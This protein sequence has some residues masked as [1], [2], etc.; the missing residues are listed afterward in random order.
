MANTIQIKRSAFNGTSAPT[1]LTAGEFAF[2]QGGTPRRVYIGRQ[3]D[4][5]G[6]VEVFHLPT[7]EDLTAGD[8]LAVTAAASS[9][10]R[11]R[12]LSVNVDDDTIEINSDTLR[13]KAD[14]IDDT[15]IDWGTGSGQVSTADVPEQTNLYYTDERVDDRI[16][17]LFV[18]GEGID[19]TYDDGNNT[20]TIAGEDASVTNKGIASFLAADF[21]VASGA[22]SLEDTVVKTITTDSGAL[23]PSTHSLSVLGGEGMNVT[24]SSTTVTVAGEDASDSN[25]GVAK[26]LAADFDNSSGEISL[27]DS[28]LKAITTDT[29]AITMASH[30][31]SVLGGEGM[32][33]THSGTAIT[34]A[35]EDATT[36]N[37]GV[38]SFA[39]A[40]FD[41]SSGAV[42]INSLS[43]SQ[44]DNSTITVG[45]STIA[46]GGSDTTL[47]GLTDID[48]V[49]GDVTIL[50]T[51][52]A[53][54]LTIGASGGT[55][56]IAGNLT[57]SGAASTI[58]STT[59]VVEDPLLKLSK[60]STT[61]TADIGFYGRYSDDAGTTIKYKGI[62]S[63]V[64]NTDT[65]TF[66][67]QTEAEPTTTVNTGG[68]NYALAGIKC[69]SV[70][71]AII[72][73]GA[74]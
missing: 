24:H 5:G 29:G 52:G 53:N 68:T 46:L 12:T 2:L 17:G 58:E 1:V 13:L 67:R 65:W 72:D 14:G 44:L 64:D 28:V 10:V 43:N 36:S 11:E 61:D 45:D 27:E 26:F 34:V 30:A 51:I 6:T 22:V 74:F 7:L 40:D 70:D 56:N 42:S 18:E 47:T 25:K 71:A 15:H 16:N 60:D 3:T 20:Y 49:A 48:M 9:S 50:D 62:F 57:V 38:A 39:S 55:V 19:Y 59:I 8:G 23:T 31:I 37:K 63:D 32:D 73:G 41:V 66:F 35:G 69:Y 4:V 21:D 54:T 33:V